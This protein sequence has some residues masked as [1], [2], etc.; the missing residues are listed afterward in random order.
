MFSIV[1]HRSLTRD[2]RVA[3]KTR[4]TGHEIPYWL[5]NYLQ[6]IHKN[7]S[8]PAIY[9]LSTQLNVAAVFIALGN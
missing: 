9:C 6:F 1:S 3:Y 8:F 4:W 2:G 7:L 5:L